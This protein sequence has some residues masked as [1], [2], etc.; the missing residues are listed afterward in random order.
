MATHSEPNRIVVEKDSYQLFRIAHK[1]FMEKLA[2]RAIKDGSREF[3]LD[4]QNEVPICIFVAWA[5]RHQKA[6]DHYSGGVAKASKGILL[7]GNV[8][9]GKSILFRTL[10]DIKKGNESEVQA[11]F[12]GVL[13]DKCEKIAKLYQSGGDKALDYYVK[14]V[15][16]TPDGKSF[17]SYCFDDLGNEETKNHYGNAREV[18]K[19][20]ID[21]RYDQYVD[22]GLITSFT[23]NLTMDEI[24]KRYDRRTRSRIEQM[25][26][27]ISIGGTDQYQDR[28]KLA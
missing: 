25:C 6:L 16:R 28:R 23:T 2:E 4:T 1:F 22:D 9:S 15:I 14:G 13:F 27:I 21:D 26:N 24:E 18:F 17:R 20:I 10:R 19:D 8:G 3:V 7:R 12:R 5:I 11:L